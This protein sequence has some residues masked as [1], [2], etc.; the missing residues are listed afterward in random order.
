MN[1]NVNQ[2]N[3]DFD[4]AIRLH[5]EVAKAVDKEAEYEA[6]ARAER[7]RVEGMLLNYIVLALVVKFGK[8]EE[9]NTHNYIAEAKHILF[10]MNTNPN[11]LP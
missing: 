6:L 1:I 4:S 5:E 9:G 11:S 2:P 8:P 10:E 7:E 3:L